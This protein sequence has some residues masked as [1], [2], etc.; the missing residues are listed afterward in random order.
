MSSIRRKPHCALFFV[1][2]LT[3]IPVS[4]TAHAEK[5]H[6]VTI[7]NTTP[8]VDTEG[9]V[10]DAHDGC[11]Q[12]FNGRYYLYGTAYGKTAGYTINNRF[13]IYS[14]SNLVSWRYE[15]ELL[16]QP[17]DGVYY[18]P[19]VAYNAI[20]RKYV[21]WFNWYKKLW[22][23]QVG[24]ATS[25]TPVGPFHIVNADV[26]LSQAKDRP[27]DG[28][29]FV[30]DD[31]S[32]YFIYTTIG[33]D[34]AIRIEKL[35]QDYLSS[36]GEAS[37]VLG[38]NCEA[39]AM[40]H[41]GSFYYA[42]FD[43][44]CCFC[45]EGSG[46]RVMIATSPLGPYQQINNINRD[47]KNRPIIHAQQT[48]IARLKTNTGEQYIWMGDMWLSRSDGIKGHDLQYWSSPLKF[49]ANGGI[50]PFVYESSWSAFVR[51]G[52]KEKSLRTDRYVWPQKHDPNVIRTDAC[53]G[54]PLDEEGTPM[55]AK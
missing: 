49:D 21:L 32:A 13:R 37:A 38:T 35:S 10:I 29:L 15:G 16:K 20:T 17:E 52:R 46:A 19:Y 43:R 47:A 42:I 9:N 25:D 27:G 6:S 36:S 23:G 51:V 41:R 12:F 4:A 2:L 34:H 33:Q 1:F 30:D 55:S 22:N 44:T 28:S 45:K 26:Q 40:F 50:K 54:T 8:R 3:V 24:V 53:Y 5:Y 14:S 39:P 31:S 11:M 7:Q 48:Y 18:R